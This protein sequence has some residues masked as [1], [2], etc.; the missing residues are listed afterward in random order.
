MDG[1]IFRTRTV[2]DWKDPDPTAVVGHSLSQ[3]S[4]RQLPFFLLTE[5]PPASLVLRE[6]MPS[7]Q[8]KTDGV[9]SR[10]ASM[11]SYMS[12]SFANPAQWRLGSARSR[13]DSPL[14]WYERK[15]Q[16]VQLPSE[17]PIKPIAAVNRGELL[18]VAILYVSCEDDEPS[19]ISRLCRSKS[20]RLVCAV[21]HN[22]DVKTSQAAE[23]SAANRCTFNEKFVFRSASKAAAS[24]NE[25]KIV[26]SR[27]SR[28]G[29]SMGKQHSGEVEIDMGVD[30]EGNRMADS[31]SRGP[32]HKCSRL[33]GALKGTVHYVVHRIPVTTS[34]AESAAKILSR[35]PSSLNDDDDMA[36]HGRTFPELWYLIPDGY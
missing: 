26:V 36:I 35:S 21:H 20:R 33:S 23:P 7:L 27:A 30:G 16:I 14:D 12:R 25:L 17:Q 29:S 15:D 34:A 22:G 11:K 32:M 5:M 18:V 4:V 13:V 9:L 10:V 1:R 6:S 24:S 2:S 3:T 31:W 19:F 28:N 8:I